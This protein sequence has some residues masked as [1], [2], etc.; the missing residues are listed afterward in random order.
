MCVFMCRSTHELRHL[1]CFRSHSPVKI[2]VWCRRNRM[3]SAPDMAASPTS[4][5]FG[6][7]MLDS[8][9]MRSSSSIM[10]TFTLDQ[11]GAL[12]QLTVLINL[13]DFSINFTDRANMLIS[14]GIAITVIFILV[15]VSIYVNEAYYRRK[16]L[17]RVYVD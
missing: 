5:Y 16:F 3:H 14:A 10:T 4:R 6:L 9:A 2:V 1:P 8:S 15:G 7:K 11:V 17:S 13:T 12:F